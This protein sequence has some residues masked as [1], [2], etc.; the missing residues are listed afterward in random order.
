MLTNP[1]LYPAI[2]LRKSIRS[3]ADTPL[4]AEQLGEIKALL[5][6]VRPLLPD[7]KFHLELA[8]SKEGWRIFG[9]CE[10]TPLGNANLGYVMQQLDLALFLKGLGRLWFGMGRDP[11][12]K[13]APKGLSYAMCLKVGNAAEPL[14]REQGEFNRKPIAEV[15][16]DEALRETF[17]P[18]RL[19]PSARNSQ[20][21]LFVKEEGGIH[22]FC[23]NSGGIMKVFGLDRMNQVDM[24]IC[25]CHAALSFGQRGMKF[26]PVTTGGVEAPAGYYYLMTLELS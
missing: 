22:V 20:P 8:P 23:A 13:A 14:S 1:T 4:S 19:A 3:Y 7:L 11:R 21:W 17:E 15:I 16:A 6:D 10:D 9:Y 12:M 5:P 25:L 2:F 18:V 26:A 24:G